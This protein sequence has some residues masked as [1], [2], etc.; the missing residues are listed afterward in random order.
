MKIFTLVVAAHGLAIASGCGQGGV[1]GSTAPAIDTSQPIHEQRF[2]RIGGID[3]WIS[4]RGFDR[5]NPILLYIH[6]GPGFPAMP[7]S[8]YYQR[9]WEEY[10]TVVQWDQRGAGKTYVANDPA[11]VATTMTPD[12]M[13][14][15]A[16]EMIGWLRREFGK[17]KIFV[18]GHSWGSYLGLKIAQRHP[19][20]LHA[21]IGMGQ[22]TDA[23]ESERRGWR[24]AMDRA[25]QS[26]NQ[27]AVRDLQSIAGYAQGN[28]PLKWK[29]V[30]LQR[31]WLNFY[32]ARFVGASALIMR[33][34]AQLWRRSMVTR[35][36][37]RSGWRVTSLKRPCCRRS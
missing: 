32:G 37:S 36:S 11:A 1:R 14:A 16:E 35:T 29:D 26:S 21:Y 27:E 4:V 20:W 24:F 10:F 12:R 6:G 18:L 17:K 3:Q 31:K 28:Q 5:R 34:S 25:R 8:W 9:G 30:E 19:E 22:I 15:D 33:S 13:I 7:T 23:M 2:V